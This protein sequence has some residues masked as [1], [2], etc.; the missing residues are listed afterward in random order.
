MKGLE[1]AVEQARPAHAYLFAGPEGVGKRLVALRFACMLNCPDRSQDKDWSCPVCRRIVE[2]KHPDVTLEKPERGKIRIE[3]IR[4]MQRFF[5]YAPIEGR[6]RVAII[7]DA[8][9]MNRQAQNALLKTLEEP[10]PNRALVLVTAKPAGL[11]PTVRSRCRRI[12][13]Q[14]LLLKPMG[15]LLAERLKIPGE[16]AQGLA[17]LANGSMGRALEIHGR[18]YAELEVFMMDLLLEPGKDG[19]RALLESSLRISSDREAALDAIE[20]GATIVR[21]M[22][23]NK[24]EHDESGFIHR[25][26]LDR[27]SLGA[28]HHSNEKLLAVYEEL[29]RAS[30]LIASEINVNCNLVLDAMLLKVVRTLAGPGMGT[31]QEARKGTR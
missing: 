26:S 24:M 6:Y 19:I 31:V 7:D 25:E 8:H 13:F 20:I 30:E 18:D 16:K 23:L 3:R 9:L 28:Q 17:A 21:D 1:R 22:L 14:P 12:S 4:E 2:G 11:L 29:S 5:K 27:I 10:P 15:E